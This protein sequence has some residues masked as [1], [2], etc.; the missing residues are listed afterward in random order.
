MFDK[1]ISV[2]LRSHQAPIAASSISS[3]QQTFANASDCAMQSNSLN[4]FFSKI[5]GFLCTLFLQSEHLLHNVGICTTAYCVLLHTHYFFVESYKLFV[6]A[7]H[8]YSMAQNWRVLFLLFQIS[9]CQEVLLDYWHLLM[10][11]IMSKCHQHHTSLWTTLWKN[12]IRIRN[13]I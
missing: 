9:W 8:L 10:N 13:I 7:L 5:E 2:R 1:S 12:D 11:L 6:L 4:L 3:F